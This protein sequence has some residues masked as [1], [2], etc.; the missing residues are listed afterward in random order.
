MPPGG[1]FKITG[2]KEHHQPSQLR[3]NIFLLAHVMTISTFQLS[4]AQL[5][6]PNKSNTQVY[7]RHS[8]VKRYELAL[9]RPGYFF[10]FGRLYSQYLVSTTYHT[11]GSYRSDIFDC[12]YF[13]EPT[14][15][16]SIK[17]FYSIC[18][19]SWRNFF[20]F[21]SQARCWKQCECQN[22]WI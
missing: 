16:E 12:N 19:I 15:S 18:W 13:G 22:S 20:I 8:N 7:F 11:M 4:A 14:L 2:L 10:Y 17:G 21:Q 9:L 3:M 1:S 6:D 5:K